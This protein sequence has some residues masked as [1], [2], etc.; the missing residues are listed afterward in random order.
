MLQQQL[1]QAIAEFRDMYTHTQMVKLLGQLMTS[2]SEDP[3]T[4]QQDRT[5]MAFFIQKSGTLLSAV[6]EIEKHKT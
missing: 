1:S 2:V 3:H 4:H 5:S 6:L